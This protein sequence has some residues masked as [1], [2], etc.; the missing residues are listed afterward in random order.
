MPQSDFNPFLADVLALK[1][2][3]PVSNIAKR[4]GDD[5]GNVSIWIRGRKPAPLAFLIRFYSAFNKELVEKGIHRDIKELLAQ[6]PPTFEQVTE[7]DFLR[8]IHTKVTEQN[9]LSKELIER[10]KRIEQKLDELLRRKDKEIMK[11]AK[12]YLLGIV[13][14][15]HSSTE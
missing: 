9:E 15:L 4:T 3:F 10:S 6:L 2:K 7:L 14:T 11:S 5:K 12:E 8:S 13:A 1:L